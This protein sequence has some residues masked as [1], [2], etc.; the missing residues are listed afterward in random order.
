[1]NAKVV[2]RVCTVVIAATENEVALERMSRNTLLMLLS[3][4]AKLEAGT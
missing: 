3:S 1:M 4:R 2:P